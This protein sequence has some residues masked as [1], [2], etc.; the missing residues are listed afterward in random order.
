MLLVE[1]IVKN[2]LCK[3]A[4]SINASLN[5]KAFGDIQTFVMFIGYPRS[6][7]SLIGALLDAH[8]N[9]IISNELDVLDHV[10]KGYSAK[11][12][13]S[14]ILHNSRRFAR[15]GRIWTGY[16][17]SVPSQWQGKFQ[18]LLII[19]DKKGSRTAKK[20]TEDPGL[21]QRLKSVISL[22]IKMIHVTRNP[23]DNIV[24]RSRGGNEKRREITPKRILKNT[25]RLFLHAATIAILKESNTFDILDI[26]LEDLIGNPRGTLKT[27][28]EFLELDC[29]SSYLD[30]CASIVYKEP[31]KTRGLFDFSDKL[32]CE[33]T[34]R[35][36]P[37]G[38][39]R[40]YSFES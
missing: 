7:H 8:P 1:C 29:S 14:L 39:F 25:D 33:I 31:H 27:I 2:M 9:M 18:K 6:G 4:H 34:E 22:P 28:C 35:M 3:I 15:H 12:I 10:E 40:G 16:D 17:Y 37:Y 38:F 5:R 36:G 30:A 26:R 13:Y 24:T 32:I 21:V 19:G 11:Q 20:F 23:F